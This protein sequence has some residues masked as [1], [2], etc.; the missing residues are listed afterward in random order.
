MSLFTCP[1][2]GPRSIE[3]FVFHKTLPNAGGTP[4]EQTF[5]RHNDPAESREHWQ[6]RYGCR[7]WLYV[8]RNP[9]TGA[10]LEVEC[11]TGAGR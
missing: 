6:H 11:L 8:R 3:E 4:F 1:Y 10:I 5:L 2:C 9:T 7:A